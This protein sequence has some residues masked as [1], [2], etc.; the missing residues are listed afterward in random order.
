MNKIMEYMYFGLPVVAY[1]L[2][3]TRLS[4]GPAADYAQANEENDLARRIAGLLDDPERREQMGSVGRG[5]LRTKLAWEH[6]APVLL[7]A[8]DQ[9]RPGRN[10]ATN[11]ASHAPVRRR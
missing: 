9:L 10:M 7:A 5:R 2:T 11:G 6:S 4:A 1:D 3:E 8:Y